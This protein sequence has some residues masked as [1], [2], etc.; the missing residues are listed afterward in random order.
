M[1][2]STIIS[3]IKRDFVD[4]IQSHGAFSDYR[5]IFV[6]GSCAD[7]HYVPR[8]ENDLDL[9][10]IVQKMTAEKEELLHA[11]ARRCI[12]SYG[13]GTVHIEQSMTVGIVKP[14]PRAEQTLLLHIVA[15]DDRSFSEL[16]MIHTNT[17]IRF[18]EHLAGEPLAGLKRID[19]HPANIVHDP[20]GIRHCM[21]MILRRELDILV[22]S[23]DDGPV[24]VP[25]TVPL[26]DD[27]L[28]ILL[29]YSFFKPLINMLNYR[30][31]ISN[32]P[33]EALEALERQRLL[34]AP[35]IAESRL[36]ADSLAADAPPDVRPIAESVLRF[37]RSLEI[38]INRGGLS[39]FMFEVEVVAKTDDVEGVRNRLR[40]AGALLQRKERE[41]AIFLVRKDISGAVRLMVTPKGAFLRLKG[42]E[43]SEARE[44]IETAV[45]DAEATYL[46]F[47]KL[48]FSVDTWF[49]RARESYL[50]EDDITVTIDETQG[51]TP[52]VEVERVVETQKGASGIR[53]ELKR[54]SVERLALKRFL[55][56]TE[57]K[58]MLSAFKKAATLEPDFTV[59]ADFVE[60]GAS[61]SVDR[62][63]NR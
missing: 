5:T 25:R 11:F 20:E 52:L 15:L 9:R 45:A 29:R 24:L 31:T 12:V 6:V 37:L 22:W 10:V 7:D 43:F 53:E 47:L 55:S 44:E 58:K 54:F 35:L 63:E 50:V 23:F 49:L 60:G 14:S 39:H 40:A 41:A 38:F 16:P 8:H 19:L 51:S 28:W 3:R 30:N 36:L 46:L 27:G 4:F 57:F 17:Y 18:H 32:D 56:T 13:S 2:L 34:D 1:D 48:G 42:G 26:D 62:P 61:S 21:R 33:L 59:I